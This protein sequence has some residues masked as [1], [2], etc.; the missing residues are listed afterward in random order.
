MPQVEVTFDIDAN[1]ILNVSARDKATG[2]EQHVT[3]TAST[4]LNKSDI[5]RMVGEAKKNEAADQRRKELVEA[6]NNA[7]S[8]AYQAEKL[9]K[10]R[11][12]S[13]P[14]EVR[15][16]VEAKINDLRD[17]MNGED[18][19]AIR[20]RTEAL[21]Q[22]ASAVMAAQPGAP[23]EPGAPHEKGPADGDEVVEGQF[24]DA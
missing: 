21:T 14:A 6:R 23:Q 20:T 5:E 11:G 18:L 19:Q 17:A 8:A 16:D 4:N 1:G 24:H 10:E 3:I 15:A 13:V 2:K 7:D 9:L 22:A 12:E